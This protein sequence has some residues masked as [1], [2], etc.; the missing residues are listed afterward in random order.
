MKRARW[1]DVVLV[2]SVVAFIALGV[3]ALWWEDVR[4]AIS[5]SSSGTGSATAPT[6]GGDRL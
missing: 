3:W 4:A 5:P 2:A 6:S 1:V